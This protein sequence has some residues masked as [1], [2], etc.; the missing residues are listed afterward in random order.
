MIVRHANL[1]DIETILGWRR[2]RAKWLAERGQD[3]WQVPWP[4]PAVATA[5]SAGQTWMV[6]DGERP[7]ATLTLT[8]W[9]DTESLW[10]L[11]RDHGALWYREDN[12]VD[13]LYVSKL[14][15]PLEHAGT[16]LGAEILDWAG[17][18]AYDAEVTWLRL[19]AWTTNTALHDYYLRLGFRHIR[20]VPTRSSGW[21]AQ[22]PTR[23]YTSHRLKTEM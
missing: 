20:T 6:C 15:V 18:R 4:R 11:D 8:A 12:P 10:K 7:V 13:A 5:I 2:E 19:D 21:C 16:G 22:R 23:R 1:G 17:G 14:T 9:T 3:Q